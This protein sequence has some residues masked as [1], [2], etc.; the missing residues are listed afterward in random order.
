MA[1]EPQTPDLTN[2][3]TR[4][5]Q[6]GQYISAQT[7]LSE[8][9]QGVVKR[10]QLDFD[11][12][13]AAIFLVDP[14]DKQTLVLKAVAGELPVSPQWSKHPIGSNSMIGQ[15]AAT[16]RPQS[17]RTGF[18]L[19]LITEKNLLGVLAVHSRNPEHL[20]TAAG[21]TLQTVAN[22]LAL[23]I[24]K[25]QLLKERDR[26]A[27]EIGTFN[28]I[29]IIVAEQRDLE[30]ILSDTIHR[31]RSL[32]QVEGAS[33]LL[34]ENDHLHFVAAA[35]A[36]AEAIKPFTL[37][38]GQGIAWTV[39]E[40]QQ[41]IRV[42]D[43]QQDPRH[44]NEID[45]TIGFTTR[46]LLAVPIRVQ[47][48]IIGVVEAMN[49][50]DGQP[51]TADDETVLESIV[52]SVAIAIQ[53]ARLFDQIRRHV[54]RVTGLLQASQGLGTLDLQDILDTIVQKAGYLLEAAHTVVYL[55]D[56]QQQ[57]ARATAS[58]S[59][60]DMV[61]VPTPSFGFEQGT[62]GWVLKHRDALCMNDAQNDERFLQISPQ[63]SMI[64]NLVAV[65]L[66]V[67]GDVIGVLE[68]THKAG[69][70]DFTVEDQ[71]LL[72]A[73]AGQAAI[74]I[75]NA[76]L[77]QEARQRVND[78]TILTQASDAITKAGN[79][80]QLLNIV[81]D[82]M[83]SIAGAEQGTILLGD[84]ESRTLRMEV[85]RGFKAEAVQLFNKLKISQD[86]GTFGEVY[87]THEILE[88]ED[89]RTD[90]RVLLIPE[91]LPDLP[92]S[93]TNI[94]L[95]SSDDEFIGLIILHTLLNEH[96]R[97]LLQS[98][99]DMAAVAI[100]KA[101]L[102][103]E[104][105]QRLAE[106]STLYTLAK[107]F[108]TVLDLDRVT[109][110]TVTILKRAL[111]CSGCCLFIRETLN[112]EEVFSLKA[113]AGWPTTSPQKKVE[114]DYLAQ[115]AKT[116]L[117]KPYPIYIEDTSKPLS[118]SSSAAVLAAPGPVS[119]AE[120]QGLD[121]ANRIRSVMIVP[122][123]VK[124]EVLGGLSISDQRPAAFEEA[125][126]R[127]LTIAAAQVSTA[128]ENIRLYGS[129]EQRA[130][131]LEMALKELAEANRLKS[132]FVQ[133]VSHELRTPLTFI[134][135]YV[136][137]ILEG[138]LG[139][140][141]ATAREKLEIVSQK[142]QVTRRLVEDI[143]S[144]QKVEAGNLQLSPVTP[145]ELVT[146]ATRGAIASASQAGIEILCQVEPG[147]PQV[148]VDLDRMA[149][150][151]D[152]LVANSLKFSSPGSPINLSAARDGGYVKFSVQDYGIGIPADKLDK[153][154]ERFYQVDGSTT[155]RYG[156]T[157][158]GL[159]II[160]QIVEAHGGRIKASSVVNQGTTFSFWLP[161]VDDL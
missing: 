27:A 106:V 90:P 41:T 103:K 45:R 43:V 125:E 95:L 131:E 3:L 66:M 58:F 88:V 91:L 29:G 25:T 139:D 123:M 4:L 59:V 116:L 140:I 23:A 115:L 102:F 121:E 82:S 143:I 57:Q 80:D 154:F 34:L 141:S 11:Y 83:L 146:R 46:S 13:Q 160:K 33:L 92:H 96:N 145:A 157:G 150:V 12:D 72:S 56:Y 1:S 20:A 18:A 153:V 108:T 86:T 98:I 67:K 136:E 74:A 119:K 54:E 126:G 62:V 38:A 135:S 137:L 152:N 26:R 161:V 127:L 148:Q 35:G 49:R 93:F 149:Q 16:A 60:G 28:Q 51:F 113:N 19:P 55:I 7:Q 107:Q 112:N 42:D 40:T 53:N 133:N 69:Q 10:L 99:A 147:L 14:R 87:R 120:W 138:S 94:P 6:L 111:D 76:Q 132:E 158:L 114:V 128:L 85:V 39:L 101:R 89:S 73:F 155:R 78:L 151:F 134:L 2:L 130:L 9:C 105:D 63:S 21:L 122:L 110:F 142:T 31:I 24:E 37:K 144:L 117:H 118:S 159:A 70:K 17:N 75:H 52:S 15:T 79:L 104:T 97:P 36:T 64:R 32:F 22:Q 84:P 44:F 68:A 109:E 81:L 77:Y 156:G 71:L 8:L 48:R 129:L 124:G 30:T 61:N 47:D 50:I 100:D 65:P 5:L